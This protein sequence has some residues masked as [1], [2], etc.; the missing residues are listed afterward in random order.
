[1]PSLVQLTIFNKETNLIL[2]RKSNYGGRNIEDS[3]G[4]S[5]PDKKGMRCSF[6][7]KWRPCDRG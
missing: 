4:D 2:K 3:I 1:M 7:I 6:N 5:S